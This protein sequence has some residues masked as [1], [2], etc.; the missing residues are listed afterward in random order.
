MKNIYEQLE[1]EKIEGMKY[2]IIGLEQF[3]KANS[4]K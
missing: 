2:I 3:M 1:Y 4:H